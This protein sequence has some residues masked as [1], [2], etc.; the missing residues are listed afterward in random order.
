MDLLFERFFDPVGLEAAIE[1]AVDKDICKAD[2]VRL[3]DADELKRLAVA[4][5]MGTYEITP[6]HTAQIPK[7]DGGVRTVY[8]N[9]PVER[10]VLSRINDLL[11]ELCGDM[12]HRACTSYQ[13]GIGC[14]KVVKSVVSWLRAAMS[15]G[16]PA[17]K[18]DLSKYFDSVP[19]A[20]IDEVFDRVEERLGQ[21][22]I[23][24][25]LR[26]YYH[27][28]RYYDSELHQEVTQ[29]QSL[30]QGC[31]V[32]AFLADVVLYDAD[33]RISALSAHYVR[34]S[35]DFLIIG[36][37]ADEGM[38]IMEEELAKRGMK[39]NPKKLEK[40][41]QYTYFKFLGFSL[42]GNDISLSSTRIKKFQ[43]GVTDALWPI[44]KTTGRREYARLTL[45]QAVGRVHRFLYGS[46][47][48]FCWATL[49]LPVISVKHD[50]DRLNG[51][52]MDAIRA[53]VTGHREIGGLGYSG[54]MQG[55]CICRGRGRHVKANKAK[56]AHIPGYVPLGA[57][58]G[59]MHTNM[60][61]Y[62]S[63]VSNP[64]E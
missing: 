33:Q 9:K 54:R 27:L 39:L 5:Y 58:Q 37:Q 45:E 57:A 55:G 26:K 56:M 35:D 29:Y 43:K 16:Q 7:D 3:C 38:R 31:A 59:A 8:V 61:A 17:Y 12:V 22:C 30:K 18:G 49:V 44:S 60:A 23:I 1:K 2:L 42:R 41:N 50:V 46:G 21:S 13:K 32:A 14:G 52:A 4:I 6:P 11:F 28:D 36:E 10:V 64:D 20:Y 62:Y 53:A 19:I 34:Y 25:I 40:L 15:S 24:T 48:R 47:S 63:L 51:Y